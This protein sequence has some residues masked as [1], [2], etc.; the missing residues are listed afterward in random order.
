MGKIPEDIDT[1][2]REGLPRTRRTDAICARHA[3]VSKRADLV[4]DDIGV[5][6]VDA[7]LN[8]Q[9]DHPPLFAQGLRG[10]RGLCGTGD[11]PSTRQAEVGRDEGMPGA[12]WASSSGLRRRMN[13]GAVSHPT[14]MIVAAGEFRG[15]VDDPGAGCRR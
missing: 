15:Q 7:V 4:Q 5:G 8:A 10:L 1:A 12:R 13:N 2:R 6:V 3:G 11:T 9:F 14:G